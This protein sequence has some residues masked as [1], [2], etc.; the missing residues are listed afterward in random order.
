MDTRH[1]FL[2]A[3]ETLVKRMAQ[4]AM[5]R[6]VGNTMVIAIL[7]VHDP[8]STKYEGLSLKAI[9][10]LKGI[11]PSELLAHQEVFAESSIIYAFSMLEAFLAECEEALFLHRPNTVGEDFQIKFG[12]V[13]E[14]E[15]LEQLIHDVVRRRMRE[16]AQWGIANRIDSL[17]SAYGLS[18][19]DDLDSLRWSAELRNRL[20]HDRR[21]GVYTILGGKVTYNRIEKAQEKAEKVLNR[22]LNVVARTMAVLYLETAKNLGINKRFKRHR[23]VVDFVGRFPTMWPDE[24]AL[25]KNSVWKETM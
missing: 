20:I 2:E 14:A 3:S 15:S 22:A 18:G 8:R 21:S 6:I 9:D 17:V 4:L 19:L 1:A 25:S 12:K 13:I 5:F 11:S 24:K 23:N 10:E 7:D 16:R